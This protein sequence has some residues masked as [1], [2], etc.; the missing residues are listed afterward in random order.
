MKKSSI[1]IASI[2]LGLLGCQQLVIYKQSS[3]IQSTSQQVATMKQ[4]NYDF[5]IGK[6]ALK[7]ENG[8]IIK[9]NKFSIQYVENTDKKWSAVIYPTDKNTR[10]LGQQGVGAKGLELD[11]VSYTDT[12]LTTIVDN[13]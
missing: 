6:R 12:G 2:T 4:K 10:I 11:N 7:L 8:Q 1:A 3:Q 5:A 13:K 9:T